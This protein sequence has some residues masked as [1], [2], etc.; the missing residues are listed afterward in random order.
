MYTFNSETEKF[1]LKLCELYKLI[2]PS[3]FKQEIVN[4]NLGKDEIELTDIYENKDEKY[5]YYDK[6]DFK[7]Y[8]FAL[9]KNVEK[10]QCVNDDQEKKTIQKFLDNALNIRNQA[11]HNRIESEKY[12][13]YYKIGVNFKEAI[14]LINKYY[15]KESIIDE[16]D[17]FYFIELYIKYFQ[18]K[19]KKM[20]N[21]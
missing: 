11:W 10:L 15:K 8:I 4:Y 19:I 17:D 3:I 7:E 1:I 13:S 12:E 14:T 20:N 5:G 16:E 6:T 18:K 2:I 21:Q 9:R